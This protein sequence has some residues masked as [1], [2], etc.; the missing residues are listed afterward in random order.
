ME[1]S[2]RCDAASFRCYLFDEFPVDSVGE[3][4]DHF[5]SGDFG[6]VPDGPVS[7]QIEGGLFDAGSPSRSKVCFDPD[8]IDFVDVALDEGDCADDGRSWAPL[9]WRGDVSESK[10][11]WVAAVCSNCRRADEGHVVCVI[12]CGCDSECC[13]F[14]ARNPGRV[15]VSLT[16]GNQCVQTLRQ[17][18]Y[19]AC[20]GES[21]KFGIW[22]FEVERVGLSNGELLSREFA[23]DRRHRKI[24]CTNAL[25]R[26]R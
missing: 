23:N 7:G 22:S 5:N 3:P 2:Q 6:D 8:G 18:E 25:W 1:A 16:F 26:P 4:I 10:R 12:E 24:L 20:V 13:S 19:R 9:A 17:E 11:S 21:S 14:D 15:R